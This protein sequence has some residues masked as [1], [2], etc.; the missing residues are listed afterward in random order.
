M[1][2]E[3][4]LEVIFTIFSRN[5]QNF[6]CRWPAGNFS[7]IPRI[8]GT[9]L[10]FHNFL[11]LQSFDNFLG[12][13]D[14]TSL[15]IINKYHFSCYEKELCQNLKISLH[16]LSKIVPFSRFPYPDDW[17]CTFIDEYRVHFYPSTSVYSR[18]SPKIS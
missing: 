16:A 10:K 8:F 14:T 11:R 2:L 4:I 5:C 17:F 7:L 13:S 9:S 1:F 12:N 6:H 15:V 18:I 3:N